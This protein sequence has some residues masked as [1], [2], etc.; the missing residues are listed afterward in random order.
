MRTR[1]ALLMTLVSAA[2]T[3]APSLAG[4]QRTVT[5]NCVD[6]YSFDARR[7]ADCRY[8]IDRSR[9]VQREAS[10]ER[11][12]QQRE[13]SRWDAIVRQAR[14]QAR[15]YDLAERSRE[16]AAE[17]AARSRVINEQ[18]QDRVRER[19][20]SVLRERSYRVR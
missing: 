4:A 15:S 17:R 12:G 5:R 2:L 18:R 6:R 9:E 7:Y 13:R 10:R 19:R 14:T 1:Y 11:A 8:E 16:R 20:D 3:V